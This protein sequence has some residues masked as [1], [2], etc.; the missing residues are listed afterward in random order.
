MTVK[1]RKVRLLS[2]CQGK[3][4]EKTMLNPI[5]HLILSCL[6][7]LILTLFFFLFSPSNWHKLQWQYKRHQRWRSDG[8]L[9]WEVDTY[10]TH[11]LKKLVASCQ[12]FVVLSC[13]NPN[14]SVINMNNQLFLN[15]LMISA[16]PSQYLPKK[17]ALQ[18]PTALQYKYPYS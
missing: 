12:K 13:V 9:L 11:N 14:I 4:E 3:I 18:S 17:I 2:I 6:L 10:L 8:M 15:P 16:V 5:P 1:S 7:L